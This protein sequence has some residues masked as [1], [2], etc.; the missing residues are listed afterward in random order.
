MAKLIKNGLIGIAVATTVYFALFFVLTQVQLSGKPAIYWTSDV[1]FPKGGHAY[2]RFQ[3]FDPQRQYDALILGSS[4]AYRG[5][6][7]RIFA[8]AG[9]EVFN[10]G[11]SSQTLMQ[12]YQLAKAYAQP[13]TTSFVILDLYEAALIGDG[14][15]STADLSQNL[16]EDAPANAILCAQ[17]DIR[18]IN[19]W[20]LRQLMRADSASYLTSAYVR[21]GY[22]TSADSVGQRAPYVEKASIQDF[23]LHYLEEL[24]ILL[25]TR[26]IPL[27]LVYS[28]LPSDYVAA[29]VPAFDEAVLPI[30]ERYDHTLIDFRTR[31][32]LKDEAHFYDAHHLNQAG[33]RL[34][35]EALLE[36]IQPLVI[37]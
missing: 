21:Q 32:P 29:T 36:R 5:Y 7:P 23:Q 19:M 11:S 12:T 25:R 9:L 17:A 28:P 3:E 30:L 33:V 34:F 22:V 27:M 37:E 1:L 14:M 10:L 2:Q 6:D 31:L 24:I 20:T 8:E 16:P 26:G 15:E 13:S 4:H 18:G 35:N